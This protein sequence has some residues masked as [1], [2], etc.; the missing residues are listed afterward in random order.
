MISGSSEPINSQ[1]MS[2]YRARAA[3][4]PVTPKRPRCQARPA[5]AAAAPKVRPAWAKSSIV[6]CPFPVVAAGFPC[7][8][9]L[10]S[11]ETGNTA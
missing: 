7:Y 1:R 3:G 11:A 8:H 10:S 5:A 6:K 9:I 4:Q 2:R